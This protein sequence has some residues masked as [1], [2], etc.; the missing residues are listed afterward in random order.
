MNC[1]TIGVGVQIGRLWYYPSHPLRFF[2]F[3]VFDFPYMDFHFIQMLPR[4]LKITDLTFPICL[5]NHLTLYLCPLFLFLKYVQ[6]H[7]IYSCMYFWHHHYLRF[8]VHLC[9]NNIL[10]LFYIPYLSIWLSPY[11][12]IYIISF[13]S[14]CSLCGR[15]FLFIPYI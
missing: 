13:S 5:F 9:V 4:I 3:Y 7:N 10:L 11:I 1:L 8:Y 14:F 2:E 6:V 15:Q 12:T